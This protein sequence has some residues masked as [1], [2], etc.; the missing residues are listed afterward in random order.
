[1]IRSSFEYGVF[2]AFSKVALALMLWIGVANAEPVKIVALGD[3]LT[4]GYGLA[5]E[6]GFVPR[7]QAWLDD[8]NVEAEIIN[9]GVSGDTSTGGLERVNWVLQGEVHGMI[10][11]LG[12]NDMLRGFPPEL[13]KANL[14]KIIEIAD[15][16]NIDVLLIGMEASSNYGPT[17]K[18]EF[19]AIYSEL[20]HI[21]GVQTYGN[22]LGAIARDRTL[23]DMQIYMQGDG[24]HPNAEGVKLI[25]DELGWSVL[26]LIDRLDHF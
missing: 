18:A 1:M 9:A 24:L 2:R 25:V 14:A 6:D 12:G 16:K 7:L 5:A 19:D 23:E 17:Y 20:E 4:Q 15:E 22:F 3:S 8:Q 11:A 21:Y 10:L 26:G 13:T